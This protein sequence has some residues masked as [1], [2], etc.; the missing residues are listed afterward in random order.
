MKIKKMKL[1]FWI[2]FPVLAF[3]QKN[4]KDISFLNTDYVLTYKVTY[5]NVLTEENKKMPEFISQRKI[6]LSKDR[7][8]IED[9]RPNTADLAFDYYD[10][11]KKKV[12]DCSYKKSNE[13][14]TALEGVFVSPDKSVSKFFEKFETIK[15]VKAQEIQYVDGK[16]KFK[17]GFFASELGASTI[18]G[19]TYPIVPISTVEVTKK[20]GKASF[21]LEEVKEV[22]IKDD[23][24]DLSEYIFKT[25]EMV[26][27][28]KNKMNEEIQEVKFNK[29]GTKLEPVQIITTKG[30]KFNNKSLSG[31]V[32]LFY[33]WSLS[34]PS[35][36]E[37]IKKLN[38]L[39]ASYK[40]VVFFSC[41]LENAFVSRNVDKAYKLDYHI[42][43]E[44]RWL[45]EKL[46]VKNAGDCIVVGK[47]GEIK[48]FNSKIKETNVPDIELTIEELIAE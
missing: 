16:G 46:E 7:M 1:L 44:S 41:V 3:A 19:V 33:F 24:Y 21:V 40:N 39:A 29:I 34:K 26:K 25:T 10:Y 42:V 2:L 23:A 18:A 43:P 28:A 47:D 14:K 17:R 9:I 12:F 15:G 20:L 32:S 27:E 37:L 11:K 30:D 4:N 35:S 31:K 48:Y 45:S 8:V 38:E 13:Q 22:K 36:P 5:A 6:T